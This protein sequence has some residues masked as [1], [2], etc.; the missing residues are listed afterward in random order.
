MGASW[1]AILNRLWRGSR[2]R[3]STA[4]NSISKKCRRSVGM[5]I[6]VWR[7]SRG[8][9]SAGA[10]PTHW[11]HRPS[12]LAR[13]LF[14]VLV[15]ELVAGP[16]EAA[17]DHVEIAGVFNGVVVMAESGGEDSRPSIVV[18]PDDD[19]VVAGFLALLVLYA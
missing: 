7:G 9:G 15:V 16:E 13:L 10:S 14:E 1:I 11:A 3:L 5:C 12:V 8:P 2:T 6:A 18:R 17:G 4:G 19:V